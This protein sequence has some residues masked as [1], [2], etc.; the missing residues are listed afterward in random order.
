MADDAEE[1]EKPKRSIIKIILLALGGPVLIG[2]G[3]AGGMF[4]AGSSSGPSE[5]VLKLIE[6]ANPANAP[7]GAEVDEDGNPKPNIKEVPEEEVFV[8]SYFEF[9]EPLTTNL[10][11][12]NRFLQVAVSISTQY[13]EQVIENVK[14]HLLALKSDILATMSSFSETDIVGKTGRDALA[15][16]IRDAMNDRLM[17][18]ENFGGVE[19]VYFSSF[20]LQ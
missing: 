13:D 6:Q 11:N 8:T 7:E 18:L 16:A 10:A 4:Y 12:S 20:V 14:T 19:H 1:T 15:A 2:A 17:Q 9:P 5:E 3:F